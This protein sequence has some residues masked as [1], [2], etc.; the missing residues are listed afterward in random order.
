MTALTLES[1]G[2]WSPH[3]TTQKRVGWGFQK[4]PVQCN[5]PAGHDGNHMW[6]TTTNAR[7]AEW[8]PAEVI[9]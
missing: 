4:V 1:C 8:G 5:R 2:S 6:S 3:E 9:R 7:L